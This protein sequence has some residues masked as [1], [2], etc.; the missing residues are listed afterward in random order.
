M[1]NCCA[2]WALLCALLYFSTAL[3]AQTPAPAPKREFRAVWIATVL[4]VDYPRLGTP[5]AVALRE[6][7]KNLLDQLQDLGF[8]AIIFQ[9]RPAADAFYPTD[10][11]PWSQF[12]TG[13]QGLPPQPEFDPLAFLIEETHGR[14]MEFHAWLNPFRATTNLDTNNLHPKHIFYQHR[15]WLV[16]YGNRLY[17]NPALPEVRI[18]LQ[19]VIRD[20][21]D[22]YPVDA[23]HFD[24]YFYP[25]PVRGV[26]FPDSAAY[27]L[28]GG[29]FT[30]IAEWR[31]DNINQVIEQTAELL[32]TDYP[33]VRF[34]ISP[35][36]VWRNKATDPKGSDSRAGIET[37]DDL[38]ADVLHWM[39]AGWLDYV[40]PQLYWNIGFAPA[41]HAL[42]LQWWSRNTPEE[43]KLIIGHGAYKVGSDSELAWSDPEEIPKQIDL[44]R[45]NFRSEGSAFFSLKSV[46]TNPLGLKDRLRDIYG[47]PALVPEWS[48]A[49]PPTPPELKPARS[50]ED[51]IWL[52]WKIDPAPS[53]KKP[54]YFAIYR[55][56]GARPGT[57]E[58]TRY[59]LHRTPIDQDCQ[60]FEFY[61]R[62]VEP[63]ST[64]T[65]V[66]TALDRDHRESSPSQATTIIVRAKAIAGFGN[67]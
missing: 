33:H 39:E 67:N 32:H 16:T 29:T 13:R 24:D 4:N 11:A 23:I 35:F 65:Y 37:Y 8:N 40:M 9:V 56:P 52:R 34:G 10:L 64:V 55:F 15:D 6:Q 2:R 21:V 58:D 31:R 60:R 62:T 41:D 27:E 38:Y 1:K 45:R 51:G 14:G 19:T 20:L 18:H 57:L 30:D 63:G 25:Y 44:N 46:L 3:P 22:R 43:V 61:D 12:L 26:A 66:V 59:L 42:L 28:Y 7:Y 50:R 54:Y 49:V 53:N 5:Q 48:A 47:T 36:G 17:L